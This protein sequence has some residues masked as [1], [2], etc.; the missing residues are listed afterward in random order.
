V[1]QN[2]FET[3]FFVSVSF[4]CADIVRLSLCRPDVQPAT[5]QLLQRFGTNSGSTSITETVKC[6]DYAVGRWRWNWK[7]ETTPYIFAST[8]GQLYTVGTQRKGSLYLE[9]VQLNIFRPA[10]CLNCPFLQNV[11][12]HCLNRLCEVRRQSLPESWACY[13]EDSVAKVDATLVNY[14]N[15]VWF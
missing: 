3:V 14:G 1:K 12:N 6:N 7:R 2:S 15:I 11:F 5:I 10:S 13:A 8:H 9:S 4:R